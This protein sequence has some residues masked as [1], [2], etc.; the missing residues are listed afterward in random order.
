MSNVRVLTLA[1]LFAWT[2]SQGQNAKSFDPAS[3]FGARPSVNAMH[4]SPDGM[5]VTYVGPTKGQ[6]SIAYTLSLA[7]GSAPNATVSADGKPFRLEG[8][9]WVSNDRIVCVIYA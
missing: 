7:K 6:G 4:L 3:A 5:S 1:L 2:T 9:H 8:C